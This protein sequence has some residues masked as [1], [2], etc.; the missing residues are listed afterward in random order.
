MTDVFVSLWEHKVKDKCHGCTDNVSG[1]NA[2]DARINEF[3]NKFENFLHSFIRA[4]VAIY[5]KTL[6]PVH[7]F[8]AIPLQNTTLFICSSPLP[9]LRINPTAQPV[10]LR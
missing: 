4:S 6:L 3:V 2:T 1:I 9:K 8:A 7:V 10:H 5:L